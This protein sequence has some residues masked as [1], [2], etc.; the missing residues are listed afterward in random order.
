M[1]LLLQQRHG[2]KKSTSTI[3]PATPCFNGSV[4]NFHG[5]IEDEFHD[6][7]D[8]PTLSDL[9]GKASSYMLYFNL[10]TPKL[11]LKKTPF[12]A[13]KQQTKIH[14]SQFM[15]FPP[16]VLDNLP[17]FAP[18]LRSVNDVSDELRRSTIPTGSAAP[19]AT[20]WSDMQRCT[21]TRVLSLLPLGRH[22]E[23]SARSYLSSFTGPTP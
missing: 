6:L 17:L 2:I 19:C 20:R 22:A 5:H 15:L 23:S 8:F 14:N 9:L 12:Q 4:E 21:G 1:K 13:V 7:E 16:L 18:Q 10:E 11:D 3:P